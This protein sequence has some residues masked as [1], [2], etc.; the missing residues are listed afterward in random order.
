MKDHYKVKFQWKGVT[1]FGI[2]DSFGDEAKKAAKTGHCI[3]E[4]AVTPECFKVLESDL[5][6]I[7]TGAYLPPNRNGFA[8]LTDDEYE[9]Y[10]SDA[11]N[12]AEKAD[13]ESEKNGTLLNAMFAVGVAD[14]SAYYVVT[15]VKGNKCDVEWRGF[16]PDRWTDHYWGYGRKNVPIKDVEP[17]IG[18]R[19]GLKKLFGQK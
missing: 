3:V 5:T 15:K 14:G 9:K 2:V 17:Y 16:C 1:R 13:K 8:P 7:K 11:A 18:R 19:R 6:D 4:D 10:V 12:A